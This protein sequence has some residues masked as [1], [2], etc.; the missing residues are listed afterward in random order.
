MTVPSSFVVICPK[1]EGFDQH[2]ISRTSSPSL[3]KAEDACYPKYAL[4]ILYVS[5]AGV[6]NSIIVVTRVETREVCSII[7]YI[8]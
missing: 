6:Q 5:Y 8:D 2:A 3:F 4:R 1:G 7:K